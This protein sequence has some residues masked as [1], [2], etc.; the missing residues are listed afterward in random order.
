MTP[1]MLCLGQD[2]ELEDRGDVVVQ[3]YLIPDDSTMQFAHRALAILAGIT[4]RGNRV[5]WRKMLEQG[6]VPP[7]AQ[8]NIRDA[9][10]QALEAGFLQYGFLTRPQSMPAF[11]TD[12]PDEAT[13]T[14]GEPMD[15]E[16]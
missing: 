3:S 12:D 14:V 9:A 8:V 16:G 4:S 1:L 11:M 15:R 6:S 13:E 7:L 10:Q 5:H 2:S